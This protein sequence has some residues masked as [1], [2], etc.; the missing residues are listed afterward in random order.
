M[1]VDF[2][3]RFPNHADQ[4]HEEAERF[5]KLTP[6]ERFL[7]I[8]DLMASAEMLLAASPK[9]EWALKHWEA[10]EQQWQQVHRQLFARHGL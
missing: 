2:P 7:A 3:Y 8:V 1:K 9:R 6:T 4:I 10:Q 5:R